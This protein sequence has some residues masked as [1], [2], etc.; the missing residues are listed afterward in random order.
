ML[1]P[2]LSRLV[3]FVLSHVLNLPLQSRGANP[4]VGRFR[5]NR[6]RTARRAVPTRVTLEFR[7]TSDVP[8]TWTCVPVSICSGRKRG[9]AC[10]NAG[11]L[12]QVSRPT[13]PSSARSSG[14]TPLQASKM[15]IFYT[16]TSR[17]TWSATN[18]GTMVA[19]PK[20]MASLG[21]VST[22]ITFSPWRMCSFAK[23]VPC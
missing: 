19:M 4:K 5:R 2:N 20:A 15:P 9:I 7:D 17:N 13:K 12:I 6:R 22:S 8:E 14:K 10:A 16:A 23:N 3:R 18:M 11:R 1:L 21:R